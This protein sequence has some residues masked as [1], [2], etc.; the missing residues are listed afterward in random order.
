MARP[1]RREQGGFTLIELAI[2]VAVVGI[3]LAIAV[4][5]Y[6]EHVIR[7]RRSEG[8]ALLM[9]VAARLERCY[10]RHAAYDHADCAAAATATSEGGWYEVTADPLTASAYTL[11]AEPQRAQAADDAGCGTLTLTHVGQRGRSGSAASCW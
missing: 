5:S 6:Q 7:T 3:L 11:H 2:A 9:E 4:P 8:Q 1:V 10:T